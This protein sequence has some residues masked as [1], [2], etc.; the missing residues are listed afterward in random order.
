MNFDNDIYDFDDE[1]DDFVEA[2]P[3]VPDRPSVTIAK[4]N[5]VTGFVDGEGS[6]FPSSARVPKSESPTTWRFIA[7]FSVENNDPTTLEKCQACIGYGEIREASS[8]PG[9]FTLKITRREALTKLVIPFFREFPFDS[10]KK[11]LNLNCLFN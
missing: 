10:K 2:R 5:Y 3:P 11:S 4:G 8:T 1:F 7:G 6:F 9:Y